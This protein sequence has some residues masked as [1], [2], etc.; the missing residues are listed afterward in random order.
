MNQTKYTQKETL[1]AENLRLRGELAQK[2]QLIQQLSQE[3]LRLLQDDSKANP[4]LQSSRN[5]TELTTFPDSEWQQLSK[6]VKFYQ[7]QINLREREISQLRQTAQQ[8]IEQKQK[9][10]NLIQKLHQIYHQKF[11]ERLEPI[12]TKLTMLQQ[13][14]KQL[15][16]E[17]QSSR[18]R[19]A[20]R[21][22][23]SWSLDL[24]ERKSESHSIP[25]F[26]DV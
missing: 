14:N 6:K 20:V 9:L 13:E 5:E 12:K 21:N 24:A 15:Q 4:A 25:T 1:Q 18:Y 3:V 7:E 2:E 26:G 19:L 10:E 8:L 23:S 11:A 16:V 17:L 22:N